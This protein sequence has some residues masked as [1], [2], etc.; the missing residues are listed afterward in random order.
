MRA[1]LLGALPGLLLAQAPPLSYDD[2]L[3]RAR[4]SPSQLRTE[5][6]LAERHRALSAS[7]G[8]LR[9]S[10]SLAAAAGPRT[11]PGVSSTSDQSLDL[12]LPLF[13]SPAVRQ[14]LETTLGQADP[15]LREATRIED[16]FRL[17]QAYLE[18]WLAE[19]QLQL[20]E[21]DLA[22]VQTWLKA[23][24]A[25]LEAGADPA[26]QVSLVEGET[27]RALADLDEARR[28]RLAVWATLQ[29]LAEVPSQPVPL[30]D[31]GEP[32]ALP[33]AELPA[34]FQA[35]VLR[36][37][38]QTRLS[39]DEQALRHQ[40]AL[41][42]SRWSLRGSY[43]R[44]G[45]ERIGKVGLAY[46]FSRPG[47]TQA[48]RRDTEASLQVATRETD[49][50][51]LNL[52]A[53]FQSALTR[54]QEAMPPLPFL[55]FS[56]ALKAIQLRLEEGRERPSEALPIRRQLLEA[57]AASYRRLQA[58]HLLSAELEALTQGVNP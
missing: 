41:A 16:R 7:R 46:R 22:T 21:A 34:R 27:L 54:A 40:E 32:S 9:D 12:D 10:P 35:G 48:I 39:L 13:L 25:R 45:E 29:A 47:E 20:R 28:Q 2:I 1:L 57:Q 14:R 58:A 36:R 43:A 33:V 6:L 17:R 19:R 53:R 50:A 5:A 18:A 24:R 15:A 51:L 49:I 11:R 38:L 31:P 4:T 23:A 52:D 44:E 37:A 8:F 42:T 3:Q 26:F 56:S 30:A 55:G